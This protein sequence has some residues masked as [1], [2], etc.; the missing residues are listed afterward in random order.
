[1]SKAVGLTATS[2][3]PE[4][5]PLFSIMFAKYCQQYKFLAGYNEGNFFTI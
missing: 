2:V 5:C 3:G 4:M 1:M